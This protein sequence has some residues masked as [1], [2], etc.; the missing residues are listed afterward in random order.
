MG[1]SFPLLLSRLQS[2]AVHDR[3]QAVLQL[4]PGAH[5]PVQAIP[6]LVQVLCADPDLNV[7]EDATWVLAR[8]GTAATPALLQEITHSDAHARHNIVHALGKIADRQAVPALI[9]ATQDGD[10]AV[11]LKAVYVLGQIGDPQAIP[12]LITRLDDPVQNV[13]YTAREVLQHIGSA[14]LPHLIQALGTPSAQVREMAA[15]L[16]GDLADESAVEPLITAL[17]TSDWQVRFAIVEA[18]GS[19]GVT[20]V[21]PVLERLLDDP[22]P[23]VR[24]ITRTVL[25]QLQPK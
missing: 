24:A 21:I 3:S 25:K 19:I 10:A 23:P 11:R 16:L 2:T 1:D 6:A 15:N 7:V 8:Y 13:H 22:E 17:N 20:S 14:A 18:L 5:N 9:V 4:Q 12:A